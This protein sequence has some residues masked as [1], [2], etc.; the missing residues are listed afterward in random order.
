[1][2]INLLSN[3]IKNFPES[4]SDYLFW[5]FPCRTESA[6]FDIHAEK[7][8]KVINYEQHFY[9][10]FP[11]ATLIDKKNLK[12]KEFLKIRFRLLAYRKVLLAKGI[13]LRIHTVCQHIYWRRLL[14]IWQDLHITDLWLSHK[15]EIL[16]S[17]DKNLPF[18]LHP[19]HLY[20]VNI[21]DPARRVG[22]SYPKEPTK[23]RYLASF[24][25]AHM[26][27]YL[28]DVRLHLR[29]HIKD[30]DFFIRVNHKWHFEDVVYQHQVKNI[31]LS[32][33]YKIDKSVEIYNRVLSESV[34]S[35]CPSGAG[36]NTL[37][38]WESM[39]VGSIPVLMGAMP[40]LPKGGT[41]ESIDW[42]RIIIH[43]KDNQI[44]ELPQILRNISL[45]EQR[46][47]Q[48]LAMDAYAKVRQ[49]RCF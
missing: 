24:I 1:M 17:E 46:K 6:A 5:Q 8:S 28:S 34:F 48:K 38:L 27:H 47:R 20:A 33:S 3:P 16:S 36:P 49:Q 42:K 44:L 25:G 9:L 26:D 4:K 40:A 7:P 11:W 15:P 21:E 23:K 45:A 14:Q 41:L 39:A 22:L 19:W 12:P 29:Q 18:T 32:E 30:L 35:L 43:V 10:G 31:A 13:E 2:D 37:R